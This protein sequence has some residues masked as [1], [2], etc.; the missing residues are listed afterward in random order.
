MTLTASAIPIISATAA[1]LSL[2]NPAGSGRN[3]VLVRY[4]AGWN[5]TTE[6][7][8][9]INLSYFSG[10]GSAT[11]TAALITAFTAIT[12]VNG[13]L[14]AAPSI[15]NEARLRRRRSPRRRPSSRSASRTLTTTGTATFR[16][17]HGELPLTDFDGQIVVPPGTF[18]FSPP[19]A[20]AAS[21]STY[22]QCLSWYESP[23]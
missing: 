16:I 18:T 2:W 23:V 12:P 3:A 1:T 6:V 4:T 5:A 22:N 14:G 19:P 13:L 15:A 11:A 17:V 20:S 8:G 10:A 21:G 7:P 9:A